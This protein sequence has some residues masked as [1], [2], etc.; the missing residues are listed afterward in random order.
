MP[1]QLSAALQITR[2][3]SALEELEIYKTF[4]DR[5]AKWPGWFQIQPDYSSGQEER[6]VQEERLSIVLEVILLLGAH[7]PPH[8]PGRESRQTYHSNIL[9]EIPREVLME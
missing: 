3:N 1:L 9:L 6:K 2:Y 5:G 4:W 8:V 7:A